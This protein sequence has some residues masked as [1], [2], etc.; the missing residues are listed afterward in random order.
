MKKNVKI[1]TSCLSECDVDSI[2]FE[3]K[4][5]LPLQ[6]VYI[7]HLDQLASEEPN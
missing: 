4:F 7:V 6:T 3:P 2:P 1:P 5:T